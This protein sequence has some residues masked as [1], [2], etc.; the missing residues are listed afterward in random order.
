MTIILLYIDLATQ[1]RLHCLLSH[2]QSLPP[3]YRN[4]PGKPFQ[5]HATHQWR[6]YHV[7]QHKTEAVRAPFAGTLQGDLSR[8]R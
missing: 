3:A 6:V 4:T 7:F 2:G 5:D 8:G 1:S